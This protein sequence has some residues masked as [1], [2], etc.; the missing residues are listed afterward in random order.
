MVNSR[1]AIHYQWNLYTSLRAMSYLHQWV[2]W[3]T[4]TANDWTKH[5]LLTWFIDTCWDASAKEV[6]RMLLHR[7]D[8]AQAALANSDHSYVN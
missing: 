7:L 6:A 1:G 2:S 3:W 8:G 4:R 5:N